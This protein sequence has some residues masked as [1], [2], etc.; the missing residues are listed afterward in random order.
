[1][2]LG[3]AGAGGGGGGGGGGGVGAAPASSASSNAAINDRR[4][5][6]NLPPNPTAEDLLR[7]YDESWQQVGGSSWDNS[8]QIRD[9]YQQQRD[10]A[11]GRQS[12]ATND[13]TR[14]YN[15][16]T[17][18]YEPLAG[19]TEQRYQQL[20][21]QSNAGSD[22]LAQATQ[23]RINQEAANRAAMYAM[24]GV[25]GSGVSSLAQNQAERGLGDIRNTQA[26]W[27]GLL[28]AQQGA[29]VNRN[30][31]DLQGSRDQGVLSKEDLNR[32]YQSF[33]DQLQLQETQALNQPGV[34]GSSAGSWVNTS[35]I[36][37]SVRNQLLMEDFY[38]RGIFE[39]PRSELDD[40]VAKEEYKQQRPNYYFPDR[41]F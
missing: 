1:M 32:R 28:G 40:W 25:G 15:D 6:A 22:A 41:G 2:P 4:S 30:K 23:D 37:D 27:G 13:L 31:V 35:G 20:I 17:A 3:G 19:Q 34:R 38:N 5:T 10:Q 39:R 16:L 18:S 11:A 12:T 26:N 14:L 8:Q 33:L 24:M 29:E 7:S 9:E 21:G 36:P